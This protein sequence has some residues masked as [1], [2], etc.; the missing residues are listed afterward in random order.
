[1][2]DGADRAG[3]NRP[4]SGSDCPA[5]GSDCPSVCRGIGSSHIGGGGCGYLV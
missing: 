1:V 3:S 4:A 5:S 2:G